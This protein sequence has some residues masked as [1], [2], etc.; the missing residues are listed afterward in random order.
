MLLSIITIN[1]NNRD[2]LVRTVESVLAQ[3]CRQQFEYIVVDG[4]S[5]DGSRE[6][7][8]LSGNRLDRCVSE[9][10]SGIYNAMNKGVRMASGDYCLFL[11]SGDVLH[12]DMAI[13]DVMHNLEDVDLVVGKTLFLNS[14]QPSVVEEPITF[15]RLY[16]GSLPHPATFIK[17]CLLNK[18]PYDETLK[19]VSDWKFFLQTVILDNCSYKIVDR[20]ISDFDCEG[21]SSVNL[22]L[23]SQE[24]EQ[25]LQG[26]FPERVL[27]D[28]FK[29][30]YGEN[31]EDTVYDMFYIKMRSYRYGKVLY[32]LNVLIMRMISIFRKGARFA[33]SFPLK[34]QE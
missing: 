3:R 12:D 17:T 18:Y 29:N 34:P 7:L 25:V 31:H 11:N 10:D 33:R 23:C 24:R 13:S 4:G 26:M 27:K 32:T 6:Y 14:M 28:Y 9:R 15:R 5:S 21:I 1:Y 8:E 16:V 2:G 30:I 20:V 22:D 19:I